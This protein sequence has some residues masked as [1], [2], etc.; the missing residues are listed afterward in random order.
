MKKRTILL[1]LVIL[2][3]LL[4]PLA[5]LADVALMWIDTSGSMNK[6]ERFESARDVLIREIGEAKPGDVL[7]IGNFDTNVNLRL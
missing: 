4:L 2:V 1:L 6:D 7:Y 5:A 3:T